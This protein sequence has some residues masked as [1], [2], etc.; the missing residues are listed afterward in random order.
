MRTQERNIESWL[1]PVLVLVGLALLPLVSDPFRVPLYGKY[2]S[3]AFVAMGIVLSWGY[4]GILSLGQGI[5][6]GIGAYSLAMF[7]KLEASAPELPDFMVWSS[8]EQLP[9]WWEPFHSFWVTLAAILLL[10]ALVS[11]PLSYLIFRKRVSG[12]YFAILTLALS[13]TLMVMIIGSQGE[14]GGANGITDFSTMLGL[15]V[16]SDEARARWYY[17]QLGLLVVAGACV[18]FLVHSRFGKVLIAI[19]DRE[20]RVRFSGYDTAL[21][22]AF[23]FAV[24]SVLASIGGA[25]FVLF[26][27]LITPQ[28]VG[29]V[30]SVEM[31]IFA[32]FGGRLS[33]VGSVVAAFS[34]GWLKSILSENFPEL[35]LFFLGA[36]FLI[37]TAV[38]PQGLAGLADAVRSRRTKRS[39]DK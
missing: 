21:Y 35:W 3:F 5:F 7:L 36:L 37:V 23:T 14:T 9:M 34:I 17:V 22:K 28:L 18:A 31:V 8:V 39:A 2:L 20:D 10:P 33:I 26:T 12:V 27:G 13:L 16:A 24:A 29:A 4:C 38:M 15:D 30:A 19:R 25:M 11:F 6:F 1:V 32:A